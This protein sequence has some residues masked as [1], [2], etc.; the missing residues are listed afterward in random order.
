MI[1]TSARLFAFSACLIVLL[2]VDAFTQDRQ[3]DASSPVE[4]VSY[5][6]DSAN[7]VFNIRTN[8]REGKNPNDSASLSTFR[9]EI[10]AN[11]PNSPA[12]SIQASPVKDE[13]LKLVF[14]I[15]VRSGNNSTQNFR[16]DKNWKTFD[17][18]VEASF[19]KGE[20]TVT[21]ISPTITVQSAIQLPSI[22]IGDPIWEAEVGRTGGV[23]SKYLAIPVTSSDT[24][25]VQIEVRESDEKGALA[26]D[27]KQVVIDNNSGPQILIL[28]D[29]YKIRKDATYKIYVKSLGSTF[30]VSTSRTWKPTSFSDAYRIDNENELLKLPAVERPD[31]PVPIRVTTTTPGTLKLVFPGLQDRFI[32][33]RKT[34]NTTEFQLNVSEL[35]GG[36]YKFSFDGVG[37][38]GQPF[39]GKDTFYDLNINKNTQLVGDTSIE[40]TKEGTISIKF[41]LNKN[42]EKCGIGLEAGS[43]RYLKRIP[44]T[45]IKAAEQYEVTSKTEVTELLT[46]LAAK[47]QTTKDPIPVKFNFYEDYTLEQSTPFTSFS[48]NAYGVT[49]NA[50]PKIIGALSTLMKDSEKLTE[51]QARQKVLEV[52]DYKDGTEPAKDS[53]EAKTVD[54]LVKLLSTQKKEPRLKDFLI[55]IGTYA[56]KNVLPKIIGIPVSIP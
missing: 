5:D 40:F 6:L 46:A 52:L 8:L 15:E 39:L 38:Q 9:V 21:H 7:N 43:I 47:F 33:A 24:L 10:K 42:L 12:R 48:V 26:A 45:F 35:R 53:S 37:S 30:S 23:A 18:H 49:S 25:K 16:L 29:D 31:A 14:P 27:L 4:S 28:N 17:F 41:K 13:P 1:L 22:E 55:G 11:N 56:F 3:I 19:K 2:S 54:T 36:T 51:V 20:T 50:T 44:A 34:G 32:Q